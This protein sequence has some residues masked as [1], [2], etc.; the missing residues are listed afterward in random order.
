MRLERMFYT[1]NLM[2]RCATLALCCFLALPALAA[3]EN[4]YQKGKVVDVQQKVNTRVLYYQVN[5]P[6]TQD[7]PY[8]EV[9][10]QVGDTTYVGQYTPRHAKDT[11]PED[12]VVS[13]D[14]QVRLEKR[15]M[16][17]KRSSGDE[18]DLPIIKRT[19]AKADSEKKPMMPAKN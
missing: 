7:D 5:T 14:V 3:I 2:K 18:L 13:A 15:H 10:V 6:I 17:L 9:S 16:F 1:V 8:Y 12:V 4:Q 11:L 19:G